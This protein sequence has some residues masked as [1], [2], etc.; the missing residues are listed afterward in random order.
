[1]ATA[2]RVPDILQM[3]SEGRAEDLYEELRD[4]ALR[5]LYF[6]TKVV[7]GYKDLNESLHLNFCNQVQEDISH[8][9]RGYLMPRGHFKSTIISKSYPLWRTAANPELRTLIVGESDKVGTK[10]MNDI[11]WHLQNN[12]LL[13]WLFPELIPIDIN[14]TKWTDSEILLP[15]AQSFDES[16]ITMIGVG[17]KT[18]GFHY[19]LII[20]DDVIGEKASKSEAEMDSVK[21]WFDYAPGLLNDPAN[22]EEILIGTRWKHGTGDLYGHIQAKLSLA[23]IGGDLRTGDFTWY[24]RSAIE[25]DAPIFPERFSL[26]T[27]ESIRR[28]E[29]EYKFNC[30]YMNNPTHPEGADFPPDW[31]RE[32]TVDSDGKT[33]IPSDGTP[34]VRLGQLLRM[35][36]LDVSAGGRTA[37]AQNAL[38]FTGESSD[39]RIFVIEAWAKN[40]P[41]GEA[42]EKW[43]Q[44][45][46]R[47]MAYRNH[48]EQV[49]AQKAVEDVIAERVSEVCRHCG[50]R[51]RRLDPV[52]VRPPGGSLNKED[53]IRMFAQAA[54]EEGRVY[55]RRNMTALKGQ[56]LAFPH[57]DLV[58][59]FDALAYLLNLTRPPMSEEQEQEDKDRE[60]ARKTLPLSRTSTAYNYGGYV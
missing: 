26:D 8:K 47:Y 35:S 25:N 6:F 28:R 23:D 9:K 3:A 52:P 10:N 4:R 30:Q 13:Q 56:I 45:N 11:K 19:D 49:G 54:F 59:M 50:A 57:G 14:R 58:D 22:G 15:R 41:I 17:A 42:I 34:S 60:L 5:S 38:I 37:K 48:Y 21:E 24:V 29:G 18:T 46:D 53:R 43:H 1:M 44:L 51:H 40:C 55:L 36:F 32:Y 27:L 20:Y 33:I 39:K 7:L 2:N 12:Q 16:T 31:L